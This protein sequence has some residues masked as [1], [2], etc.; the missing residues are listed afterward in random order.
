M[1]TGIEEYR[2]ANIIKKRLERDDCI[3]DVAP[4]A[5]QS[6]CLTNLAHCQ[7]RYAGR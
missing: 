1:I 6:Y 2:L 3:F 4:I 7:T 5:A